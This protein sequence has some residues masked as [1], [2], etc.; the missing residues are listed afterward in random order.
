MRKA[1]SRTV[2]T[3]GVA[4]ALPGGALA[5]APRVNFSYTG[6]EQSYVVPPG[7]VL[8]GIAVDGGHGG[9]KG[10]QA[11]GEGGGTAGGVGALLSVK[12]G[13]KF[14]VEVGSAGVYDGAATFGG[15][16]AAGAPPPVVGTSGPV[17]A[18][19]GGGASDV[20]TCSMFATSCPG[21]VSSAA[22]RLLEGGGGG[23]QPGAGNAPSQGCAASGFGARANSFQYPPGNPG[24]GPVP[25]IT[26]AGIVYPG[27]STDDAGQAG[28]TPAGGGSDVAGTGGSIAGC[29]ANRVT[30][31][32][33]VAGSNAQGGAGGT[34]G[35]ASA[36]A[37]NYAT[38]GSNP[39]SCFDA[40]PGGG[41]GGGYF[42]GGGGATGTDK[43]SGNCGACNGASSGQG[44]AGGSSFLSDQMMD[45]IDAQQA[46]SQW[47]GAAAIVPA[48][49][50]DTPANGA[51]YTPGQVVDANWACDPNNDGPW[52]GTLSCTATVA[53]G[54][55]IDTTPGRHTF[56][57]TTSVYSNGTQ[58]V[59]ATVTYTVGK[60]GPRTRTASTRLAGFNF[61]LTVPTACVAPNGKLRVMLS[62][63]G[64]A[65]GYKVADF[66]YSVGNTSHHTRHTGAVSLPVGTLA[67]GT[68]KLKLAITLKP[69]SRNGKPKTKTLTVPF[70]IC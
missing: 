18:S 60:P 48:I 40:G 17:Y 61:K 37:P 25:I 42:G 46:L 58:T 6:H 70:S 49:E 32:D 44:G 50:I 3:I 2:G 47:N 10:G 23:G 4:L 16:G 67:A 14:F 15:G 38:C 21:G 43:V 20:R 30:A 57:V 28:V 19:S 8:L 69:T 27:Y 59:R 56:T 64:S 24:A 31:Y 11:G 35:D 54:S 51:V 26:A 13:E 36:L 12:P 39:S 52:G 9:Q 63:S 55:P 33:S 7:V 22:S 5:I 66:K 68:H 62:K 65:Q 53:N 34:G 41:G 29:S 45:P 1:F